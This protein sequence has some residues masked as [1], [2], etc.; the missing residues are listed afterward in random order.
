MHEV[1]E[2]AR[3]L[4]KGGKRGLASTGAEPSAEKYLAWSHMDI[5]GHRWLTDESEDESD[6]ERDE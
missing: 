2:R 4:T 3:G 1:D 6:V 5:Q